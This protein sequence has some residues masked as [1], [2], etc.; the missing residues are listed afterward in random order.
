V[1]RL[2]AAGGIV[3][4]IALVAILMFGSSG[5]QQLSAVFDNAGQLVVGNQVQVGGTPVGEVTGIELTE[6]GRARV[7]L[8][9]EGDVVPLHRGTTAVIRATSL[10]G[11]ANRY[12]SLQPGPND[13]EEIPDGGQIAG[14][15]TTAPV[16]LDQLFNALDPETR[17]GLQ[18]LVQGFAAQYEGKGKKANQSLRYFN[19]ALS[20]ASALTRELVRDQQAFEDLVVDTS[21]L[22][23]AV[24]ERRDDLAG[25]VR[26]A[27]TTADA[28]GDENAALSRALATV[29]GTLRKSNTT[30]VNLRSTIDDL[31][32]L[33]AESKPATR[34]LAR[35]FRELRPLV[36]DA[37]PTVEDLRFLVRRRG[38]GNDLIELTGKMPRLADLAETAWPRAVRTMQAAQPV[39]EYVRP[40]VPDLAGYITKFGQGA[41]PYDANGH[42]ARIQP[43]FNAFSLADNPAGGLLNAVPPLS[44]LD[45]M[46]TRAGQRCP[47]GAMPPAPDGSAPF[48]PSDDFACDPG[49]SPGTP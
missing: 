5:G 15:D 32:V 8:E 1:A 7:D 24:A 16:D 27:G 45:G 22:V 35:L 4:A 9:V 30:F 23:T 26:N 33:V 49:S 28:I 31:D 40:Y 43:I 34:D 13:G 18:Q 46:E 14:D 10:S 36:D 44:R 12:V 6:D 19:P 25:L 3:A 29:P 21:G 37:E 38:E 47:G 41:S 2:G 17:E 48:K 42:Y 11:I 39:L 20:T